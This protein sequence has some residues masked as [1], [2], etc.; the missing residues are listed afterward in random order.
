M[1]SGN[2]CLGAALRGGACLIE[3]WMYK[4]TAFRLHIGLGLFSRLLCLPPISHQSSL[5]NL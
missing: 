1:R 3:T 5:V 4:L 2:D